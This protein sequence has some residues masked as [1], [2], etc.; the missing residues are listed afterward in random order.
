M[1]LRTSGD[2]W[3]YIENEASR[4]AATAQAN[5]AVFFQS[6]GHQAVR[7]T[8]TIQRSTLGT[9]ATNRMSAKMGTPSRSR[10]SR[11]SVCMVLASIAA[12]ITEPKFSMK[13]WAT[14]AATRI[15]PERLHRPAPRCQRHQRD[16]RR[17]DDDDR[18]GAQNDQVDAAAI[19]PERTPERQVADHRQPQG[20]RNDHGAWRARPVQRQSQTGQAT[21]PR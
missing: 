8:G 18:T 13:C 6:C 1:W 3:L 4:V 2:S 7:L 9:A 19:A 11:G 15:D 10:T 21:R 16:R 17:E 20:E 12:S 14:P 5:S